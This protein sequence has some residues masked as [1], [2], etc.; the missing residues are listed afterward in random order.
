MSLVGANCKKA[1]AWITQHFCLDTQFLKML[2]IP[3]VTNKRFGFSFLQRLFF[4]QNLTPL[5]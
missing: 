2:K 3:S 4:P 1:T 5:V